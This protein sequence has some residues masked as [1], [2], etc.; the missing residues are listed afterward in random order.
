M[1]SLNIMRFV[2]M[3]LNLRIYLMLLTVWLGKSRSLLKALLCFLTCACDFKIIVYVQVI[4]PFN[5]L[6]VPRY[7]LL[8]K[9]C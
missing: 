8:D 3:V 9:T 4:T 1:A 7:Y 2:R 6:S 5:C